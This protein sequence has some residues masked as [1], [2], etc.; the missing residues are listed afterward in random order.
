M[1]T[2]TSKPNKSKLYW[3]FFI[4]LGGK[5]ILQIIPMNPELRITA[6]PIQVP[7]PPIYNL[8]KDAMTIAT[9]VGKGPKNR[10]EI[11]RM[12]DRVSKVIP[13]V[14]LQGTIISR[15]VIIPTSNPA[16][17]LPHMFFISSSLTQ[18]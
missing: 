18:K 8:Y 16:K 11:D 10:P 3:G 12:I 15:M 6:M 7:L 2:C 14:S 5:N 4:F 1:T 9:R 13:G 17:I